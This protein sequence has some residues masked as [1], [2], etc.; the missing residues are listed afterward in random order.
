MLDGHDDHRVG[1]RKVV[2]AAARAM[3]GVSALVH[4]GGVAAVGAE[5]VA[6]VPVE[7]RHRIGGQAGLRGREQRSG[8]A[9]AHDLTA[10][11]RPT[12]LRLRQRVEV[13]GEQGGPAVEAEQD[14]VIGVLRRQRGTGQRGHGAV[15]VTGDDQP[16]AAGGDRPRAGVPGEARDP[17]GILALHRGPVQ[18]HP[19]ERGQ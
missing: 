10:V 16:V 13:D 5:A 7:H 6:P 11:D 8:L 4:V 15:T 1:P 18:S 2:S 3:A 19:G 9:Q 12:A 14:R 17:L